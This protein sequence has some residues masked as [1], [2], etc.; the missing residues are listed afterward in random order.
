MV[1]I[2]NYLLKGTIN[3]Q[4]YIGRDG[5]EYMFSIY[6]HVIDQ[7]FPTGTDRLYVMYNDQGQFNLIGEY[8]FA[9]IPGGNDYTFAI[10][11]GTVFVGSEALNQYISG[12][13][14]GVFYFYIDDQSAFHAGFLQNSPSGSYLIA[15]K[16]RLFLG[17]QT[18]VFQGSG[19]ATLTNGSPTITP[20][21]HATTTRKR[22]NNVARITLNT[23]PVFNYKTGDQLVLA[24]LGGTGYNGNIT[25]TQVDTTNLA[26]YFNST[27][28]DET[29]SAGWDVTAVADTN[30]KITPN[31]IATVKKGDQINVAVPYSFIVSSGLGNPGDTYTNNSS[32]FTIER[33]II[34]NTATTWLSQTASEAN[35]WDGLCFATIGGNPL[36]VAVASSGTHAVMTSPDG[37]TW[38]NRNTPSNTWNSVCV[39]AVGG[40]PLFVAAGGGEMMTSPDGV[41]WTLQTNGTAGHTWNTI[42]YGNGLFVA[43]RNGTG[44]Q[45]LTS[46]DGIVWTSRVANTT[47]GLWSVCYG[48]GL[49]IAASADK[50]GTIFTSPDGVTWTLQTNG[51]TDNFLGP[52]TYGNNMYVSI[53]YGSNTII[54]S[55]DGIIWNS[56]TLGLNF[57]SGWSSICYGNGLFVVVGTNKIMVSPD[58]TNWTIKSSPEANPWLAVTYGNGI[59][60]SVAYSGA[61]RVMTSNDG[62]VLATR[63]SGT[64]EPTA[65]GALTLSSGTGSASISYYSVTT[66][67]PFNYLP[68]SFFEIL[69]VNA[70]N[71]I[72]LVNNYTGYTSLAGT[73]V[74]R[75]TRDN[76]IY[77]SAEDP[78]DNWNY[79][80]TPGGDLPGLL[81]LP[82]TNTGL[83]NFDDAVLMFTKDNGFFIE[84]TS[85]A[86]W[87]IPLRTKLPAGCISHKSIETKNHWLGF[88][89]TYG[90]F[91]TDGGQLRFQDLKGEAYSEIIQKTMNDIDTDVA[92]NIYAFI[93][94]QYLFLS[95]CS[96]SVYNSLTDTTQ[97]FDAG[98]I[99]TTTTTL[100]KTGNYTATQTFGNV[101]INCDTTGGAFQI[102]LP[103]A[104]GN[105]A[106]FQ[107]NL[108]A[109]VNTL[110]VTGV[111]PALVIGVPIYTVTKT[112]T[113]ESD[114]TNWNVTT[115]NVPISAATYSS[116]TRARTNNVNTITFSTNHS[117]NIGDKICILGVGG[118]GY[119]GTF[120]IT[121]INTNSISYV[122]AY[123]TLPN[124][125]TTSD[126][127]GI[128]YPAWVGNVI[129]NDLIEIGG[130]R[131]VITDVIDN[132]TMIVNASNS[133]LPVFTAQPYLVIKRRNNRLIVLDTRTNVRRK[134]YGYTIFDNVDV[135]SM[136]FYQQQLYYA[137]STSPFIYNYDV[138]GQLYGGPIYSKFL[139]KKYD[140]N[141][142]GIAKA[143][144]SLHFKFKGVGLVYITPYVNGVA[145]TKV[146]ISV[147]SPDVYKTYYFPNA[148]GGDPA[149]PNYPTNP[150]AAQGETIQFLVEMLGSN[151]TMAIL[152]PEIGL[153]PLSRREI[154]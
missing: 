78:V 61:H 87:T 153:L 107:I 1:T 86:D 25:V 36:F 103:A 27:G 114:D 23:V 45:I 150:F 40:N 44:N 77:W 68:I 6:R 65:S 93:Y 42:C 136:C 82:N 54:F 105:R 63:S 32:M 96:K 74:I 149:L 9:G 101:I 69:R 134:N 106:V 7:N 92:R 31:W 30:G 46:P 33:S 121:A 100:A 8:N 50:S 75:S 59:F 14:A 38:T 131:Y 4:T 140:C 5:K 102:T 152:P 24:G 49:F 98:L 88:M 143:F 70:D 60:V 84:G 116:T 110:T 43:V 99:S 73:Y 41:T 21:I 108:T 3:K 37:Q 104:S 137:S 19:F 16:N 151:E 126:M 119:D 94:K 20:N 148:N 91:I 111:L 18:Q 79:S 12:T 72:T 130:T 55:R 141:L 15:A 109:G 62:T 80:S 118:A 26:I 29:G 132:S 76:V 147:N 135:D 81:S 48:N 122:N 56:I 112:I 53:G 83:C 115:L 142:K 154:N 117:Y 139:T 138:G 10:L 57:N 85:T 128:L 2:E 71:T 58:G 17:G 66:P 127:G 90:Y 67:S 22:V 95:V 28:A 51:I 146:S 123:A 13:V 34:K 129:P 113:I 124:E 39:G 11:N 89:S 64:N 120:T 35:Y 47:Y 125:A 133:T 97:Q 144:K 52:I 145:K